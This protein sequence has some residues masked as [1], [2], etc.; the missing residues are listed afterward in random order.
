MT[1]S[2]TTTTDTADRPSAAAASGA[3][4]RLTAEA[5]AS[6]RLLVAMVGRYEHLLSLR[7]ATAQGE[8]RIAARGAAEAETAQE[9]F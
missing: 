4:L 6:I 1:T 8:S 3:K 5:A 2:N 7:P 9:G